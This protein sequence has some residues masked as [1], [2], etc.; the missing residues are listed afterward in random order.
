MNAVNESADTIEHM[1][2]RTMFFNATKSGNLSEYDEVTVLNSAYM[3]TIIK[4]KFQ[5]KTAI[6][7]NSKNK[8]KTLYNYDFHQ[9]VSLAPDFLST[10]GVNIPLLFTERESIFIKGRVKDI[11]FDGLSVTCD[12]ETYPELGMVCMVLENQRPPNLRATS[13]EGVYRFSFFHGV[14]TIRRRSI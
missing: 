13:E 11:L 2:Q 12:P 4:V 3:G 14:G 1:T 6:L 8:K 5:L 7:M 9:I 10:I